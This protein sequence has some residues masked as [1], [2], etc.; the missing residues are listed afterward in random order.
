MTM[1]CGRLP[2]L[3]ASGGRA[4]SALV[5]A[6]GVADVQRIFR[7][8]V[9]DGADFNLACIGADFHSAPH[10]MF[11]AAYMQSL[12]DYGYQLAPD[13]AQWHKAPPGEGESAK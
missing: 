1:Y 11:D 8:A 4:I 6:E 5:Q 7:T 10:E 9:R 12:F 13:G 3:F 2:P